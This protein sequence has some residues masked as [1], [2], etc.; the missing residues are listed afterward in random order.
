M[1]NPS[2]VVDA[3]VH[4]YNLASENQNPAGLALLETVYSAHVLVTGQ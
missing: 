1:I 2:I 4:P 3:V